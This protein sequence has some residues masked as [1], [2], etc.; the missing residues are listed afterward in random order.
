M[1]V[2]VFWKRGG[3][4]CQ[5]TDRLRHLQNTLM[6][7][8]VSTGRKR[9][10]FL[11]R[12]ASCLPLSEPRAVTLW[13]EKKE[14]AYKCF[15]LTH[16]EVLKTS[17]HCYVW[18]VVEGILRSFKTEN[19]PESKSYWRNSLMHLCS[20]S[21]KN[22]ATCVPDHLGSDPS[23]QMLIPGLKQQEVKKVFLL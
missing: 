2:Y 17:H 10:E 19:T 18:S 4:D 1:W 21:K 11:A 7:S 8:V 14:E 6:V 13:D 16:N 12:H 3:V 9:G 20:R 22:V 23:E 5:S 15:I